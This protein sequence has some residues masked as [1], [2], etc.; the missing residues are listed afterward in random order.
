M[1]DAKQVLNPQH[2]WYSYDDSARYC[3]RN[4][5]GSRDRSR[6]HDRRRSRDRSRSHDRRMPFLEAAE[7]DMTQVS[8]PESTDTEMY[9]ALKRELLICSDYQAGLVRN[10]TQALEE[11]TG[12]DVR[13]VQFREPAEEEEEEEVPRTLGTR[14]KN[15]GRS[16]L[17]KITVNTVGTMTSTT[18]Q[19]PHKIGDIPRGI[20][21]PLDRH[22]SNCEHWREGDHCSTPGYQVLMKKVQDHAQKTYDWYNRLKQSQS[23]VQRPSS[24]KRECQ[25]VPKPPADM[26]TQSPLQKSGRLQSVVSVMKREQSK[27]QGTS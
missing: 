6:S 15:H 24:R 4:R 13:S 20:G 22:P 23:S 17:K 7:L 1:P 2:P 21:S 19:Q 16:I 11:V 10:A 12:R 27:D 14:D 25:A 9:Q 26:P 5:A 3:R 8:A 18:P